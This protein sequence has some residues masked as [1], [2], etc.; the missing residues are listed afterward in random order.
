MSRYGRRCAP[1]RW[2]WRCWRRAQRRGRRTWAFASSTGRSALSA[3]AEDGFDLLLTDLRLPD[4]PGTTVIEQAWNTRPDL[5]VIVTS[6]ELS[7]GAGFSPA[8]GRLAVLPKPFT[9]AELVAQVQRLL[10]G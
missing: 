6:G 2:R 3:L 1:G 7:A 10:D 9:L 8:A 4:I 5:P